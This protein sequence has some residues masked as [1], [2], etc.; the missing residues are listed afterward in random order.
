MMG[1]VKYPKIGFLV[2][3]TGKWTEHKLNKIFLHISP[4]IF[5]YL[6]FFKVQQDLSIRASILKIIRYGKKYRK[7]RKTLFIIP[8]S[9]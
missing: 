6:M 9:F 7:R 5:Q 4:N 1:W 3:L 8:L 2:T